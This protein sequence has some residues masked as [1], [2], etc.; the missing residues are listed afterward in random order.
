VQQKGSYLAKA[1]MDLHQEFSLTSKVVSTT[2]DNGNNYV[3][4]F[5]IASNVE[6]EEQEVGK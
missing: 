4:A 1:M 2:T 3:A 6:E 5:K